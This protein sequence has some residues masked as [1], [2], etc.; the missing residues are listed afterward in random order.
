[1]QLGENGPYI[2]ANDRLE[3]S[4]EGVFAAGDVVTG[5]KSVIEAIAAGRLV[6]EQMDKYLGGTGDISEK[7]VEEE[8][9]SPYIGRVENFAGSNRVEPEMTDVEKRVE[10][11]EIVEK[12]FTCDQ[13]Q[14]EA[15]RCLQCDLRLNLTQP[16]LWNE[17]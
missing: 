4:M 7:L 6:A 3:T 2:K 1:M 5:T 17:Y 9:P 15:G 10:G 11:F 14:C 16:K 12:S 8:V 13:A